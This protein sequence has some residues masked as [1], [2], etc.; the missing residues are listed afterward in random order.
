[1]Y[2]NPVY[3]MSDWLF[4]ISAN[5]L[6]TGNVKIQEMATC[7]PKVTW[8]MKKKHYDAANASQVALL[9]FMMHFLQ[10]QVVF[11]I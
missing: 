7:H 11:I 9:S 8:G 5:I 3:V 2:R 4:E 6:L 10:S 1:M